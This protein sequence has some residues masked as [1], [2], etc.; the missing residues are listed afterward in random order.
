MTTT[1]LIVACD[2]DIILALVNSDGKVL[3][4]ASNLPNNLS[5]MQQLLDK[6]EETSAT[7]ARRGNGKFCLCES[8]SNE[9]IAGKALA[10]VLKHP[11]IQEAGPEAVY[12]VPPKFAEQLVVRP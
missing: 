9:E 3:R 12:M 7:V 4:A 10:K 11:D 8:Y 1:R 5:R 2:K 6:R